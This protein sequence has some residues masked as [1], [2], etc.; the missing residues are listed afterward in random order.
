M[1]NETRQP[2]LLTPL[3][4][5]GVASFLICSLTADKAY[6]LMLSA[7]QLIFVPIMLQLVGALHRPQQIGYAIGLISIP[8]LYIFTDS[9]LQAGLAFIYLLLTMWVAWIGIKRFLKRGFVNLEEISIEVGMM[10]LSVGGMWFFAHVIEFDTGFS[11]IIT[12][13]TGIHF[14]Y[15]AFLLPV[16][17]GL[18]GRMHRS[19]WYRWVV[20]ILLVNP[21]LVAIGI[22]GWRLIEVGSVFLYIVA[23][24]G[25]IILAFRTT[26]TSRAQTVSLRLSYVAL[27][28]AIIFSLLYASGHAFGWWEIT[29][30]FMLAFHG[31]LN[32]VFF[33]GLS[34]VGWLMHTPASRHREWSFP[35]SQ[36]RGRLEAEEKRGIKEGITDDLGQLV[37]VTRLSATIRHFYEHTGQFRLFAT[38]KWAYWFLPLAWCFKLF[39]RRWEQ[40]NLPITRKEVEMT[41][42]L[43][44]VDPLIDGRDHPRAWIRKVNGK[45]VFTA[46]YDRHQTGGQA[47]M[48][49]ALPLPYTS[50]IGILRLREVNGSLW[51][52]SMT[53]DDPE[54]T[55]QQAAHQGDEGIYLAAG[56]KVFKLPL[57]EFFLIQDAGEHKLTAE[58]HMRIFGLPFLRIDY[59]IDRKTL[60]E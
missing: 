4:I 46:I 34:I 9:R 1:N 5:I 41:C 52:T 43:R 49:T 16:S 17:A 20:L 14:H 38:V 53:D 27:G 59:R 22:S 18:L 55:S 25:L 30:P 7:A 29:I 13:L 48:N 60:S 2:S 42:E 15:A 58:H 32:C 39:S 10:Y 40:L 51:I 28:I 24:F 26:F 54:H 50:M 8:A 23:I 31:L 57:S 44:A 37:D 21:V 11:P 6:L 45:T 47:Y 12:W 19:A 3:T 33:G 36:I 56:K 35:V